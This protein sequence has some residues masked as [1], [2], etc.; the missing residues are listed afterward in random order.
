MNL[1][2]WT[3]IRILAMYRYSRLVNRQIIETTIFIL[4]VYHFYKPSLPSL[5][6][7]LITVT[8]RMSCR[9]G[10]TSSDYYVCL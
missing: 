3:R 6:H 1:M 7:S 2:G 8:L 10:A 9:H 4:D 5:T